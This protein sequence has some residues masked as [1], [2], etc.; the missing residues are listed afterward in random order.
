MDK[1]LVG[2]DNQEQMEEG[3]EEVVDIGIVEQ[4]TE[5]VANFV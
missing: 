4:D 1:E 2:I 3:E 5:I